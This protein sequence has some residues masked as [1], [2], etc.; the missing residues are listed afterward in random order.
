M[1]LYVLLFAGATA[2]SVKDQCWILQSY[3]FELLIKMLS[4]T[5]QISLKY[6]G[7]GALQA[8]IAI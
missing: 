4:S 3:D 7:D 1:F 2:V 8:M 6:S 5:S